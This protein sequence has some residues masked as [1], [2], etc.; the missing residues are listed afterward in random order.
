M[1]VHYDSNALRQTLFCIERF[2][3]G[4]EIGDQYVPVTQREHNNERDRL[5]VWKW[6]FELPG[7]RHLHN[8]FSRSH[9][10]VIRA[11]FWVIWWLN[12]HHTNSNGIYTQQ[13]NTKML[14]ECAMQLHVSKSP[15]KMY[16]FL[17][18]ISKNMGCH[19][20]SGAFSYLE[21]CSKRSCQSVLYSVTLF[22]PR[23][24]NVFEERRH[25]HFY[26]FRK[27]CHGIF[28]SVFWQL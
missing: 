15:V 17:E 14:E 5:R 13:L 8:V 28:S 26:L 3:Q 6:N 1:G 22:T 24:W 7:Q 19:H 18:K 10:G 21:K 2:Y 25:A 27:N 23:S 16:R 20:L 9:Q 11:G 4:T 12:F